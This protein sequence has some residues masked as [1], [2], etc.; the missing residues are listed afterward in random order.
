MKDLRDPAALGRALLNEA[1]A[2]RND[3]PRLRS[4]RDR[5]SN[6]ILAAADL[7]D[8]YDI[9]DFD[10]RATGPMCGLPKDR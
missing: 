2:I 4:S 1:E 8:R 5:R 10:D 3:H 7:L 6:P 9:P